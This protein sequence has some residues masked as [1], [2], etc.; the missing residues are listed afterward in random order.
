M[1][2]I[3]RRLNFKVEHLVDHAKFFNL[4][5]TIGEGT[6][7]YKLFHKRDSFLVSTVRMPHLKSNTPQNIS[8]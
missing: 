6:F 7:I 2:Y 8:V 5:T 3:Q 4:H 1:I